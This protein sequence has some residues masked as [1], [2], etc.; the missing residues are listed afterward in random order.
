VIQ[1]STQQTKNATTTASLPF[2]L[3][4]LNF[5]SAQKHSKVQIQ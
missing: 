1:L 2:K 3:S 4:G 5:S